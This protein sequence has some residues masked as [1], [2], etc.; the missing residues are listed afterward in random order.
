M[1]TGIKE[2]LKIDEKV[3]HVADAAFYT[4]ENLQT[5]G[6]HTFW[7]SRVPMV[8]LE[9]DQLRRTD[10]PFITCSDDRYSYYSSFS[11]YAGIRQ[12]LYVFHSIEQQKRKEITFENKIEKELD[13]SRKSLKHLASKRFACEPDAQNAIN[14]W[15]MKHPW[16]EFDSYS[17]KQ[18]HERVEKKRGRPARDEALIVKYAIEVDISINKQYVER[19]RAILGRFIVATNDLDLDPESALAYYKGQYQVEKGFRF[20]KDKTFRVSEVFLKN[21][22]RIQALAMI[23]VLCLYVYAVSEFK[24]RKSLKESNETIPSQTGKP[25]QKPTM[26]WVFFL[27]R[28]V[29]E[30]SL[31]IE[32]KIITK[33][34]NLDDTIRKIL[35][36]LGPE[37][38][39]YYFS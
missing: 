25:T 29:R 18:V 27:F 4:E 16:I 19:E 17:V 8:I 15:I 3:L 5:L 30:L 39:K 2:N 38:K 33:V 13:K 12:K 35:N 1:V 20:L 31:R 23:M 36:L 9:A 26:R 6:T 11:E 7:I 14:D 32:E 24:L 28:R 10:E 21:I 37:Y 34:L 22:G